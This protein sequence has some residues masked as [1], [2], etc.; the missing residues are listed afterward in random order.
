MRNSSSK[1]SYCPGSCEALAEMIRAGVI[2]LLPHFSII[3]A[4]DDRVVHY[5]KVI[6]SRIL[7]H[8]FPLVVLRKR[9]SQRFENFEYSLL[10][11]PY[12]TE[13]NAQL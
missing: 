1:P 3:P 5:H 13:R 11:P 9:I 2:M 4:Q 6:D 7:Y 10:Q 8:L 12:K